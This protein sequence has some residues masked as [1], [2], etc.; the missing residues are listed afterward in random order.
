MM[1]LLKEAVL[2]ILL[3]LL[4]NLIWVTHTSGDS[5]LEENPGAGGCLEGYA[6]QRF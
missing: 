4:E 1:S 2:T 5:D 6:K 3:W